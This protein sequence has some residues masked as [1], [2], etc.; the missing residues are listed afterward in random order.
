MIGIFGVFVSI[1]AV[2][3]IST[4]KMLRFSP[5][6]LKNDWLWLFIQSTAL[7]LPVGIV[8]SGLVLLLSLVTKR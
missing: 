8:V 3:V 2:I 4:D 5:D 7:F 1:F 6:L